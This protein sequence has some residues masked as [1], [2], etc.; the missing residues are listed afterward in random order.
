MLSSIFNAVGSSLPSTTKIQF[1]I[2]TAIIGRKVALGSCYKIAAKVAELFENQNVEKLN[3]A[4][5]EY[6]ALASKS[7]LRD[8][9]LIA[10]TIA[11]NLAANTSPSTSFVLSQLSFAAA[12]IIAGRKMGLAGAFKTIALGKKIL[13]HPDFKEWDQSSNDYLELAKK[14]G[15]ND[16]KNTIPFVLTGLSFHLGGEIRL[17]DLKGI[18]FGPLSIRF[19]KNLEE[20][21]KFSYLLNRAS[22]LFS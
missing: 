20:L 3:K 19:Y 1:A 12:A 13:N 6:F 16:V 7:A 15:F 14:D 8:L 2:T 11:V 4:S 10:N 5:D 17:I 21:K 22:I 18:N 9:T